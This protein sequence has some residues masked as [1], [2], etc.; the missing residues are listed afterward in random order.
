MTR[1]RLS[2]AAAFAAAFVLVLA[3]VPATAA[4]PVVQS[5]WGGRLTCTADASGFCVVPHPAGVVPDSV[6]VTPELPA[7][8]SVDQ[9]TATTFRI[10]F[11]RLVSSTGACTALTGSRAFF[12][13]LDYTA[14]GPSPS[15]STSASSASPVPSASPTVSPTPPSS[16]SPTPGPVAAWPD[17]SNTG[18]P[19]GVALTVVNGNQVYST[20]NQ[21]IDAKDIRGC[22]EV[23]AA[24]VVIKR[25][26]ISAP[27]FYAVG[28]F[29][30]AYS[31]ARLTVQDSE[32]DCAN[33]TGTAFS[34]FNIDAIRVNVHGCENGFDIHDNV[35]VRDSWVHNLFA[36]A[37]SH[38]DGAQLNDGAHDV[39]FDHNSI[40][41]LTDATSAII[42]PRAS[43]GGAS[44]V[45][46]QNNL[47]GGGSYALYCVQ[48]GAGTNYRV[49]GNHFR[50]DSAYGPWTDCQ[51][52]AVVSG[53]VWDDNNAPLN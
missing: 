9:L 7:I 44:N 14:G 28:S 25:S 43:V 8:V 20:P 13:H 16:P 26:K 48:D 42:S 37:E 2:A 1:V 52:E 32:V 46:V 18:V 29:L 38:T 45:L 27:C 35:T 41:P 4:T 30:G 21:V 12:A 47:L 24:G 15:P 39:V 53:N 3:M 51:D 31:G 11:C 33:T 50:R 23:R 10:R 17:A 22:V 5:S 36:T 49:I 34:E 6:T 19:A 40:D